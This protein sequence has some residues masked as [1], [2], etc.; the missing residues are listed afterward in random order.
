FFQAEDGIRDGHVTGV[1]TCA[2]PISVVGCAVHD[3][4]HDAMSVLPVTSELILAETCAGLRPGTPD[5]G[6]IVGGA[7]PGAP[8]GLMLA[9]GQDRK[10]VVE[11]KGVGPRGGRDGG[12]EE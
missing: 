1:Q 4:L 5:N 7:G 3:L 11:G 9:T 2:L 12:R 8:G 6:P 10:S